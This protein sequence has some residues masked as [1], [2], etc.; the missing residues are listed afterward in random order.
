MTAVAS[1]D[2][3]AGLR[4]ALGERLT[5]A[6]RLGRYL[7]GRIVQTVPV[8]VSIALLNFL[9]IRLAPGDVVDALAG[10]AGGAT[11]EYMAELR[12]K[13][14]LDQPAYIQLYR[15]V[16]SLLRLDLGYSHRQSMPVL[17][18]ILDR[19]P[20]TILLMGSATLLAVLIGGALG[21]VQAR[22]PGSLRDGAIS[23][24][25]LLCH[26]VPSFLFGLMAIVYLSADRGWFPSGGMTSFGRPEQG[27]EHLVD[28][29]HHLVLPAVTLANFYVVIYAR[30][31]RAS[32]LELHDADFIRTARAKGASERRVMFVHALRNALLPLVTMLG[33]QVGSMLSGAVIVESVFGWPGLGRLAFEAVVARDTNLLLGILFLSSILVTLI[34]ILVDLF[35]I[36]LD[37]RLSLGGRPR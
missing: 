16:A 22:R 19:L 20:A 12:T 1:L 6:V 10:D 7:A 24:V 17:D 32:L 23:F 11:P 29:L 8:I 35:Y 37:P 18:L 5:P 2:R 15:Y 34:N 30:L 33:V 14:G 28:V 13:F 36:L 3:E 9:I 26:A 4:R 27:L 31:L 21:V 25:V